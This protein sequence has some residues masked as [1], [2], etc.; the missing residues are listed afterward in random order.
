MGYLLVLLLLCLNPVYGYE[1]I[2]TTCTEAFNYD[3][4]NWIIDNQLQSC[5]MIMNNNITCTLIN[6]LNN[7]WTWTCESMLNIYTSITGYNIVCLN[8]THVNSTCIAQIEL[9]PYRDFFGKC[10][11]YTIVNAAILILV[12]WISGDYNKYVYLI[13][14]EGDYNGIISIISGILTTGLMVYLNKINVKI[15][16]KIDGEI[17]NTNY[18]PYSL[19]WFI[20]I[21]ITFSIYVILVNIAS[22]SYHLCKIIKTYYQPKIS[23]QSI[24]PNS[25]E[26]VSN[27][28]KPDITI[29][30]SI[31]FYS[32]SNPISSPTSQIEIQPIATLN[33]KSSS[34]SNID[35]NV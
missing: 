17:R 22:L 26:S 6:Q 9:G 11:I 13:K 27:V 34:K 23:D 8:N 14:Y 24:N 32:H 2:S 16:A 33:Q 1:L 5:D 31:N 7:E 30:P 3:N 21:L 15:I 10:M 12:I 18:D 19:G 20:S 25:R 28:D 29:E 35:S 4:N